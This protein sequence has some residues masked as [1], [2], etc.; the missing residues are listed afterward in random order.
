MYRM[1]AKQKAASPR[2]HSQWLPLIA[3]WHASGLD[4]RIYCESIGVKLDTFRYHRYRA[5]KSAASSKESAGFRAVKLAPEV[6]HSTASI[7][8]YAGH[9]RMDLPASL[10]M[11]GIAE[12]VKALNVS[13]E[14]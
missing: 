11:S 13:H 4:E 3:E 2:P 5:N 10:P 1:P 8:L 14:A 7:V 9:C 6:P 12:L